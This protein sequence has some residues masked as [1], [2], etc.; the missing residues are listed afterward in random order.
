MQLFY[1]DRSF[2]NLQNFN[3]SNTKTMPRIVIGSAITDHK[4]YKKLLDPTSL[5]LA[6]TKPVEASSQ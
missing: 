1:Y 6:A 4:T 5:K 2:L 3:Y